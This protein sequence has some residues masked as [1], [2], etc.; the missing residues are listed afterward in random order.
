[1][2]DLHILSITLFLLH[3]EL[4]CRFRVFYFLHFIR[5]STNIVKH[6]RSSTGNLPL[7]R[8]TDTLTQTQTDE[9]S[10][11]YTTVKKPDSSYPTSV[12]VGGVS[13]KKPNQIFR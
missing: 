9:Q 7:E 1:M 4:G 13:D 11:W 8:N 10:F 5:A 12:R 3:I 2:L 6:I